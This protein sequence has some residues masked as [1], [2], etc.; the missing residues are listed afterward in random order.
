MVGAHLDQEV[1][2]CLS[3]ALRRVFLHWSSLVRVLIGAGKYLVSVF[4]VFSRATLLAKTFSEILQS[5]F[6]LV[7]ETS[8]D[9]DVSCGSI[10]EVLIRLQLSAELVDLE[11][12]FFTIGGV[13]TITSRLMDIHIT[14]HCAQTAFEF[15][16]NAQAWPRAVSEFCS[17]R[18]LFLT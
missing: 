2:A 8:K 4:Q 7:H 9:F 14:L 15:T 5:N 6:L 12:L 11:S 10:K 18:P 1:A 17:Q 3:S 13:S 16:P